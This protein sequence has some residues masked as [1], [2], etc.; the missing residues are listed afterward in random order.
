MYI[1]YYFYR[2]FFGLK[3][4]YLSLPLRK[5]VCFLLGRINKKVTSGILVNVWNN[6]ST[7]CVQANSVKGE[8]YR[9]W[10]GVHRLGDSGVVILCL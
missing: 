10:C 7:D 9:M 1:N 3:V 4:T 8:L 6:L 2:C 5:V